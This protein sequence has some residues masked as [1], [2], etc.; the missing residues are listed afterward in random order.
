[1]DQTDRPRTP[2]PGAAAAQDAVGSA[3]DLVK[4]YA[5]LDA[6]ALEKAA[7]NLTSVLKACQALRGVAEA[8]GVSL[9]GDPD[10]PTDIESELRLRRALYERIAALAAARGQGG[11]GGDA[12]PGRAEGGGGGV[13]GNG[14]PRPVA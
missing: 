6:D 14:P 5:E 7:R 13:A 10:E 3:I 9:Q 11:G 1:M 12:E 2:P 8:L 4:P